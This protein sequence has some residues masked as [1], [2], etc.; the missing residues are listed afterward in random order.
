MASIPYGEEK[1]TEAEYLIEVVYR[2]RPLK[3]IITQEESTDSVARVLSPTTSKVKSGNSTKSLLAVSNLSKS[4]R[5]KES[6]LGW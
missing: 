6:I 3:A 2:K 4:H 5:C 1:S